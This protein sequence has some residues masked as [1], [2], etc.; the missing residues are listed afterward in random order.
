MLN[1]FLQ[2]HGHNPPMGPQG[3]LEILPYFSSKSL[4]LSMTISNALHSSQT[5][6]L[7]P[8]TLV[9]H[10][11]EKIQASA[12]EFNMLLPRCPTH[13]SSCHSETKPWP[14]LSADPLAV[15]GPV[16]SCSYP[17][18]PPP[19]IS[20]PCWSTLTHTPSVLPS[21]LNKTSLDL[22]TAPNPLCTFLESK[23]SSYFSLLSSF[24]FSQSL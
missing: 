22:P 20:H 10:F 5:C 17:L 2:T 19:L 1:V 4:T 14:S 6:F 3:C 16:H 23:T 18:C 8:A 12:G 24:L 21:V 11:S 9:S 13:P 7:T 15:L